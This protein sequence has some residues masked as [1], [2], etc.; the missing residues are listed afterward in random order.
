MRDEDRRS[1]GPFSLAEQGTII[2]YKLKYSSFYDEDDEEFLIYD[3]LPIEYGRIATY[4]T[5]Y[6]T[7]DTPVR[8][9]LKNI[10][11]NEVLH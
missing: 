10:D 2:A 5:D 7:P 1:Y 3:P 11:C 4:L 9:A 8:T 6:S